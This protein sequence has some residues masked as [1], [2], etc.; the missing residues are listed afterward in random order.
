MAMFI[1]SVRTQRNRTRQGLLNSVNS[2][3]YPQ[4]RDAETAY[5]R[6]RAATREAW[7]VLSTIGG[8]TSCLI[9]IFNG[10]LALVGFGVAA[11]LFSLVLV[12]VSFVERARVTSHAEDSITATIAEM[13]AHNSNARGQD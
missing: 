5:Y 9:G 11:L 1:F 2:G 13:R 10:S 12:L 7:Q 3:D 6:Q 8:A 4:Y